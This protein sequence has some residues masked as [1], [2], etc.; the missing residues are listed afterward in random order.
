MT[1]IKLR[2]GKGLFFLD[3]GSGPPLLFLHGWGMRG[4]YFREQFAELEHDFRCLAP[5]LRGHGDSGPLAEGQGIETLVGDIE[6]LLTTTSLENVVLVGWSM[7]AMLCWGLMQ[8]AAAKRIAGIVSID[9]VPRILSGE[10]WDYGLRVGQ[11][12]AVFAPVITRMKQDW[13][14]FSH[15]FVPRIFPADSEATHQE[16]ISEMITD[17]EQNQPDSMARLW[18]SMAEQDFRGAVARIEVPALVTYGKKSRLYQEAASLWLAHHMPR[19]QSF[20]FNESGHAPHLEEPALFNKVLS[21]F[22][23]ST[24]VNARTD[25]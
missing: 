1:K 18:M 3:S 22:V 17:A 23:R 13:P 15:K 16:L 24:T 6:E 9:M 11:D 5:D 2:D 10:G 4:K 14:A 20:A 12:A 8:T 7:G 21:E 25:R 19:G